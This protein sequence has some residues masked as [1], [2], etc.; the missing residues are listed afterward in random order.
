MT[1][2]SS[3]V[4]R[5]TRSMLRC[6]GS[7]FPPHLLQAHGHANVLARADVAA[8]A[9]D[10]DDAAACSSLHCRSAPALRAA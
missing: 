8:A 6:M 9:R 7:A 5:P 3:L 4:V 2:F 10:L 1:R